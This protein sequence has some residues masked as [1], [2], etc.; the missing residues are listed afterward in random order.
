MNWKW[1]KQMKIA[2]CQRVL[3]RAVNMEHHR[4]GPRNKGDRHQ[5]LVV[6]VVVVVVGGNRHRRLGSC[7]AHNP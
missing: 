4:G 3:G 5:Q 2:R 1:M 6:V 7:Y